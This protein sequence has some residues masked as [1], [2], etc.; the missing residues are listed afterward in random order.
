MTKS[1]WS[2][3]EWEAMQSKLG[4]LSLAELQTLA[5]EVG[6][7][8]ERGNESVQEKEQFVNALDECSREELVREYRNILSKRG[9]QLTS[10]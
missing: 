6:I 2:K 7:R 1:E 9:K 5:D 3:S 8:F 4:E 10:I